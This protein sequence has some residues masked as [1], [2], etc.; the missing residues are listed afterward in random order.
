M[1][2]KI[3]ETPLESLAGAL[4]YAMGIEP[5]KQ[6]WEANKTLTDYVDEKLGGKKADRIFLYNADAI[7]Q[8]VY[9]KYPQFTLGARRRT[10]IELPMRTP[11]PPKTPVCFGTMYTGAEPAAHGITEYAKKPVVADTIFDALDRAGKKGAI[12]CIRGYSM[13][14]IFGK[15]PAH[16]Y[17]FSDLGEV[18]AK[19]AELIM[20]DEYDFLLVYNGNYDDIM[21]RK[22][23]EHPD[24][25]AQMMFN[26]Q[27]FCMFDSLV[28][29]HW[30]KHNTLVG[31]GMDHGC[32]ETS[33]E[34]QAE[35]PNR[36]G[37]HGD[38]VATD[39]NI[40]HLYKIHPAEE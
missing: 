20:K 8:W 1:N 36:M 16:E 38:D 17:F 14:V 15:T 23:P 39:R 4:A 32:H 34:V 6:A 40:L 3:N 10:D 12:V 31:F 13:S 2:D 26:Y 7:A 30:K 5:P 28:Q 27:T 19:A 24:S 9:E 22:G 21:H 25:L 11:L 35:N 33:P 18:N 37:D 29:N